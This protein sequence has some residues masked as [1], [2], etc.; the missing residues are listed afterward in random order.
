MRLRSQ[1]E[2]NFHYSV[3][4]CLRLKSYGSPSAKR[5]SLHL[6]SVLE[7]ASCRLPRRLEGPS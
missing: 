7:I 4:S 1:H 3:E 6:Y 5:S 2:F